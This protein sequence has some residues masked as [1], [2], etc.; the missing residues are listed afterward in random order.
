MVGPPLCTAYKNSRGVSAAR[1]PQGDP[2]A[3][4]W[5]S[6]AVGYSPAFHELS[7]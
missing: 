4:R 2:G 6:E 3:L 1:Q 7:M 5:Y